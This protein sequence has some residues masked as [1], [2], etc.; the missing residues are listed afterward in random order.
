MTLLRVAGVAEQL[1]VTATNG[2]GLTISITS[3]YD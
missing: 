2:S 1:L 3:V